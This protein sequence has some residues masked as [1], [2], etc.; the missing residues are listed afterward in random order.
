[1]ITINTLFQYSCLHFYISLMQWKKYK[2]GAPRKKAEATKRAEAAKT[3]REEEG[4]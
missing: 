2:K 1:M 4:K 3:R